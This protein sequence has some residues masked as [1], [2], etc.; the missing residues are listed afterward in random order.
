MPAPYFTVLYIPQKLINVVGCKKIGEG[1]GCAIIAYSGNH[2]AHPPNS[3]SQL[4]NMATFSSPNRA[5]LLRIFST[6]F[7]CSSCFGFFEKNRS[8]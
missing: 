5:R 3:R 6:G 2:Q 7:S 1:T 4:S 8:A